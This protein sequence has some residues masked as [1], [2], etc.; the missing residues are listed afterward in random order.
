MM[1]KYNLQNRLVT[2][3]EA[4]TIRRRLVRS[5]QDISII[6]PAV[7]SAWAKLHED[8][9]SPNPYYDYYFTGQDIKAYI[10]ELG[11]HDE[12]GDMPI[13][14]LQF[15]VQQTKQPVYG[16]ASY[17]YDAVMRGTRIVSGNFALITRY[18]G[19]MRKA[20]SAAANARANRTRR[21]RLKD[22]PGGRDLTKDD[23]N[24]QK[25][26]SQHIDRGLV[27]KNEWS[28]HPPFNFVVQYGIQDTSV[29]VDQI[30]SRFNPYKN[31]NALF[32]DHN[33]RL[34]AGNQVESDRFIIEACELQGVQIGHAPDGAL[35]IEVY[36]FFGRDI[37]IPPPNRR[38]K[39]KVEVPIS[40]RPGRGGV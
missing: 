16:Y 3:N 5:G 39:A 15:N 10:A 33:Q 1:A 32:S 21:D 36:E 26:W 37:I 8:S 13:Q 27:D 24:I 2:W 30:N 40:D 11:D 23:A 28:I 29:P 38:S 6:D 31:D 20:L 34:V 12:F 25:Y 17:T 35:A 9:G 7:D 14:S 19:Y 22:N 18:P 4:Q